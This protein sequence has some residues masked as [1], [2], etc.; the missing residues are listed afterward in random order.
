MASRKATPRPRRAVDPGHALGGLRN[1][2]ATIFITYVLL[3]CEKS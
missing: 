3:V 2:D 1:S